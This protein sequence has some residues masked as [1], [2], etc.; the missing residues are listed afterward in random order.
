MFSGTQTSKK[1]GSTVRK[2]QQFRAFNAVYK[3][4]YL[5][6]G[7]LEETKLKICELEGLD[8]QSESTQL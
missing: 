1:V 3:P 5:C 7:Y 6:S 4:I 8:S 2:K